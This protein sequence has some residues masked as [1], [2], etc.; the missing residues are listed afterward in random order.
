[1]ET[2]NMSIKLK[3]ITDKSWIVLEDANDSKLGL[4]TQIMEQYTLMLRGKKQ[5]FLNKKEL[6]KYFKQDIF[7]KQ[8]ED[9]ET[10]ETSV[11]YFVKGYPINYDNPIEIKHP[12]VNLP[13]YSK[14]EESDVLY[15]AGYY[16]INFPK[17][18]MPSFCPKLST[19]EKYGYAGPFKT[20]IE[21]KSVLS[22]KRKKRNLNNE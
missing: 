6:T 15:S 16:C 19:L 2:N 14:K 11:E 18:W 8:I 13:L 1:M 21:M 4:L 3:K 17:N 22:E 10:L 12:T 20:K 7:S 9:V 5:T